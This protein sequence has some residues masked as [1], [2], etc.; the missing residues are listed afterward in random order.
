MG[1]CL[2]GKRTRN[3]RKVGTTAILW[4]VALYSHWAWL[5]YTSTCMCTCILFDVH[6]LWILWRTWFFTWMDLH[7]FKVTRHLCFKN[8]KN[9]CPL[10][11]LAC[12]SAD[13]PSFQNPAK[14]LFAQ[15]SIDVKSAV[16]FKM[17]L[18]FYIY[19]ALGKKAFCRISKR[20]FISWIISQ[21]V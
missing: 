4:L 10:D 5:K 15:C 19:G 18:L 6:F 9:Q 1:R 7:I 2:S 12:N 20:W 17:L 21:N 16:T 13:K 8:S 14:R 3:N 11:I